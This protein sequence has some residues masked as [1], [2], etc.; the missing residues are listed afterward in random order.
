MLV[1]EELTVL[2]DP[3]VGVLSVGVGVG[4]GVGVDVDVDVDVV[5]GSNGE[6]MGGAKL[7]VVLFVSVC[8]MLP[9]LTALAV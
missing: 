9:A 4:V 7:G 5:V 1:P 2:V 3:V 6:V 8:I